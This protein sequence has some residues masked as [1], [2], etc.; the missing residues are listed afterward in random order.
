MT[1]AEAVLQR[2]EVQELIYRYADAINHNE[3]TE[4]RDCWVP[5]GVFEQVD[6]LNPEAGDIVNPL[7]NRPANL[8]VEGRDAITDL[9]TRYGDFEWG[10]QIPTGIVVLPQGRD[11]ARIRHLLQI[12][13]SGMFTMGFCYDR[14]EREA[15]GI[16]RLA[17]REFRPSYFERPQPSGVV[18]RALPDRHYRERPGVEK[19]RTGPA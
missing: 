1:Y 16:W 15:D 4:Y 10:F 18:C 8:R 14:A 9:V 7:K 6:S 5:S 12:S 19:P 11:Q 17:H 13:T 3:W 2:F